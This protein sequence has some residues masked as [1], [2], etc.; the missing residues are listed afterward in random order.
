MKNVCRRGIE[1]CERRYKDIESR[2]ARCREPSAR[3]V[4]FI[5]FQEYYGLLFFGI[6]VPF[7]AGDRW[8]RFLYDTRR[9]ARGHGASIC[10]CFF[11]VSSCFGATG[12]SA[13]GRACS[14]ALAY[15]LFVGLIESA[16]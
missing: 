4:H 2:S 10:E 14:I 5:F 12:I 15:A 1:R 6:T 16:L 9:V 11:H 7:L 13:G 3:S 8:S